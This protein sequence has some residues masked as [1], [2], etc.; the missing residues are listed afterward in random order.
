MATRHEDRGHG[1]RVSA[2]FTALEAFPALAESRNLLLSAIATGNGASAGVTSA[3][4]S[5][6]ALAIAVLRLANT[7]EHGRGR[8]EHVAR[9][10]ELLPART[11]Q[12]LASRVPTFDFFEHAGVW[13][14]T[15]A[16]FRLHALAT[17]RAADKIASALGSEHRERIAVTS[18]LHDI[19]KLVL[20]RAYPGYPS[21]VHQGATTPGA[22]NRNERRELGIDHAVVGGVLARRWGLPASVATAIEHHHDLD[23]E[24]DAAIIRLADMLAHY[25]HGAGVCPRE[26][27]DCARGLG[28]GPDALRR[29]MVALPSASSRHPRPTE[30]CPLTGQELRILQ[31]LARGRVYKEI[32]HELALSVSTV[33]TH[34]H[35]IYRKLGVGDRAQAVIFA[36]QHGWV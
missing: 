6:V 7:R 22:R 2:A 3:I 31:G 14:S 26:M 12:A 24:G 28:L 10:V 4:E 32:A 34:L 23:A 1:R 9:A 27:L 5:D 29:L 21:Q 8:V 16:R 25:E 35:N 33:R 13:S 30:P 36:T 17:Q 20:I 19:G 18:M 15:P 11:V